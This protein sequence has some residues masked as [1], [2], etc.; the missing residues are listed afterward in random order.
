MP[1][2]R[3]LLTTLA[4]TASAIALVLGLLW[5][6]FSANISPEMWLHAEQVMQGQASLSGDRTPGELIRY[7]NRRLEGHP[8]LEAL[9]HPP[10]LWVQAK[11]ER[12]VPPGPLPTLGKGQQTFNLPPL[13]YSPTGRPLEITEPPTQE[14]APPPVTSNIVLV[15]TVET[16]LNATNNAAPGQTI[17]LAPGRYLLKTP[18]NTKRPGNQSQPITV[19]ADFSGQVTIEIDTEV[20]FRVSQPYWVFENLQIRGVCKHHSN[21][22]HAFHIFGPAQNTTLRNNLLEDF[23]AHLKIN[24]YGDQW[25]DYGLVQ[26][27]TLTNTSRRET[28]LP[29]TAIDIVGANSWRLVDNVVTNFVKGDGNQIS[30]GVFMKGAGQNGRIERNLIVC[31]PSNISQSGVRVGLSFGGGGTGKPYCRD[32]QCTAEHTNGLAANNIVAHCNDFGIDV[33]HSTGAVIAHNTVINTAG[34]D[35]RGASAS[36]TLYGNLLDGQPRTRQT[37]Q[38][39]LEMNE[40]LPPEN[41]VIHA[42]GLNLDW[43]KL[44][45]SIPSLR[46]VPHDFC[47]TKRSDGTLPGA[48]TSESKCQKLN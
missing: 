36:A 12:P 42:D 21:C 15:N 22:E 11:V 5:Y 3:K 24:G 38:M 23:N 29:V 27:N 8:N 2:R 44:P 45:E 30:Y 32:K 14:K 19:R 25:P 7:V 18:I 1:R 33:N 46:S 9:A 28:H 6:K 20:G 47:G 37:A 4:I 35:V 17:V 31:T 48:L 26:F 13:A 16:L 39:K 40:P 41:F 10:L 43:L 34:I